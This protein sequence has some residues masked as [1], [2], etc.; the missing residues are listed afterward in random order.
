MVGLGSSDGRDRP[1]VG[2][3]SGCRPSFT[4]CLML[5]S[6]EPGSAIMAQNKVR[7][8]PNQSNTDALI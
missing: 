6:I 7:P 5:D 4:R 8:C 2:F 1:G 3:G